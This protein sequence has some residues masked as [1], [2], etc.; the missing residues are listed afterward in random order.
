MVWDGVCW[1]SVAL[2]Y[3]RDDLGEEK[4]FGEQVSIIDGATTNKQ[5]FKVQGSWPLFVSVLST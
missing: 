5:G 4:V 2:D 3:P 1:N